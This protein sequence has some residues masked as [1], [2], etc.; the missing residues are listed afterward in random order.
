[1]F[2]AAI[3]FVIDRLAQGE[4]FDDDDG[5]DNDDGDGGGGDDGPVY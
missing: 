1:M 3:N 4:Q 5:Y 2:V